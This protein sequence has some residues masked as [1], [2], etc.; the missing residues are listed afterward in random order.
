MFVGR[1]TEVIN[2]GGVKVH[3]LPI[4]EAVGAIDGVPWSM[5]TGSRTP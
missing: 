1:A 4:E 5:R 2:V 3:P